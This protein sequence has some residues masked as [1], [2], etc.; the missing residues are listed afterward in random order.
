MSGHPDLPRLDY[1]PEAD[2]R[3][4]LRHLHVCA[5]CRR[6]AIADDPSRVFALLAAREV[7]RGVLERVS[8][9]VAEAVRRGETASTHLRPRRLRATAAWAAAA[10]LAAALLLPLA[11]DFARPGPKGVA[12]V[13]APAAVPRAG[14]EVVSPPGQAQVVNLTVGET[15][16]VM[17]F[18][19]RIDL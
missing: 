17:I 11:G 18:D 2:R 19:P 7:P 8:S 12:A 15:Q 9:G 14:A 10:A 13:L 16:L 1:L 6:Q 4:V 3:E 5:A